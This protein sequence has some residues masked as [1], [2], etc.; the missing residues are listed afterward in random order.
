MR[1]RGLRCKCLRFFSFRRNFG[2]AQQLISS[3]ADKRKSNA[4]LR[5]EQ[6]GMAKKH[7]TNTMIVRPADMEALACGSTK[8]AALPA[9]VFFPYNCQLQE[10]P[11]GHLPRVP[12]RMRVVHSEQWQNALVRARQLFLSEFCFFFVLPVTSVLPHSIQVACLAAN[13]NVVLYCDGDNRPPTML[14][15]FDHLALEFNLS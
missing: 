2:D 15:L 8:A 3:L 5:W 14:N 12:I 10:L 7:D 1:I 11:D 4:S 6:K 13:K 9:T